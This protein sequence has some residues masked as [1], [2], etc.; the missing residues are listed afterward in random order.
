M[1]SVRESEDSARWKMI[2][3]LCVKEK[4]KKVKKGARREESFAQSQWHRSFFFQVVSKVLQA[5][6]DD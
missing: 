2:R 6:L 3:I 5:S 4:K 1:I